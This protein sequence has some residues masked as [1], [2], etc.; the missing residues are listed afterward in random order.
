VTPDENGARALD[1]D[2]VPLDPWKAEYGYDP[3]DDGEPR[4]RVYSLGRDG[5]PGGS[6]LGADIEAWAPALGR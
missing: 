6:G 4:P 2:R 5:A 1:R 3:P